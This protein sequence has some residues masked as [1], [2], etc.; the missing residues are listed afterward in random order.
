MPVSL[1]SLLRVVVG[2]L[3]H[4]R[5]RRKIT[6]AYVISC[7]HGGYEVPE[8]HLP[9][10]DS[11]HAQRSLRSHRGYDPGALVAARQI[12]AALHVPLIFSEVSRLVIELNRCETS[13]SLFSE[14]CK[15][16]T[17]Q[18]RDRL[19]H[20][21]YRPYRQRVFAAVEQS[22]HDDELAVHISVHSFVPVF[23][24][25]R[26]ALDVGILFDPS[27]E[28]EA[29]FAEGW[30]ERLKLI[31]PALRVLPNSPYAGIDDGLTTTCRGK[32][33]AANYVGI[34]VEINSRFARAPRAALEKLVGKI[35]S[36][37]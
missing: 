14:F 27:R 17:D 11:P 34:E 18:A 22:I 19:I 32:Y 26:R 24:G 30:I 31:D 8:A 4:L 21:H 15:N 1:G 16:L 37:L 20:E 13:D 25:T 5:K 2:K 28:P 9:D 7:E 33:P 6:M 36:A 12:A 10:F 29:T 3:W 35:L 23:H